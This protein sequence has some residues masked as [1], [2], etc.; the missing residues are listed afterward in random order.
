MRSNPD[1]PSRVTCCLSCR[2]GHPTV[3]KTHYPNVAHALLLTLTPAH[4]KCVN[5]VTQIDTQNNNDP[6]TLFAQRDDDDDV[7]KRK[8]FITQE[9]KT[10]TLM[11]VHTHIDTQTHALGS[12]NRL[13][14]FGAGTFYL[15]STHSFP[16]SD[17]ATAIFMAC[18]SA[19]EDD[20]VTEVMTTKTPVTPWRRPFYLEGWFHLVRFNLLLWQKW[21]EYRS[22]HSSRVKIVTTDNM[23]RLK[24]NEYIK[25]LV[26]SS[27]S[28]PVLLSCKC[29]QG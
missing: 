22:Y 9:Q 19:R 26:A 10:I 29:L 1:S 28:F 14:Q 17:H 15:A 3:R 13:S 16:R 7:R 12:A 24:I 27:L 4:T 20:R 25:K 6:P 2:H 23:S 8:R 21:Q 11:Y 5:S 18:H